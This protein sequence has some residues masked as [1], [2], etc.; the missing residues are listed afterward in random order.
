MDYRSYM[1]R[2][3]FALGKI[4]AADKIQQIPWQE[5]VVREL[6]EISKD[7]TRELQTE[8]GRSIYFY[9]FIEK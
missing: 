2:I 4:K 9:F 8:T 3:E 6:N 7:C 1:K 5:V